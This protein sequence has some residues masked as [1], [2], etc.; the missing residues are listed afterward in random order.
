MSQ[1]SYRSRLAIVAGLLVIA[2]SGLFFF[3]RQRDL[4]TKRAYAAILYN[5][6]GEL[7]KWLTAS[8][9]NHPILLKNKTLSTL[10]IQSIIRR[11]DDPRAHTLVK[12]ILATE[13]VDVNKPEMIFK[14]GAYTAGR[15][16]IHCAVE[17]GNVV[18]VQLLAQKGADLNVI[19]PIT[20]KSPL[21][22]VQSESNP[23]L[24][25]AWHLDAIEAIL[26][27]QRIKQT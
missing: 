9:V 1:L 23:E 16:P 15:R 13:G 21:A 4:Y 24:R 12:M 7:A 17:R 25:A 14:N 27:D 3:W 5:A 11:P 10:L 19:D 2:L 18:A 26:I 8:S 20:Q 6:P 22:F